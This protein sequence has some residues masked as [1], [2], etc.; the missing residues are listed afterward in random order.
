MLIPIFAVA[1]RTL[2]RSLTNDRPHF[3]LPATHY[4][5]QDFADEIIPT[6][7]PAP[8]ILFDSLSIPSAVDSS[9]S[10][11]ADPAHL[12]V[13]ALFA[14]QSTTLAEATARY[15]LRTNRAPPPH[16]DRWFRYAQE[17][18]CLIDEYDQ[19]HRD[20]KPFYQLAE[21]DPGFFQG[22]I[23][24]ARREV[25]IAPFFLSVVLKRALSSSKPSR[26]VSASSTYTTVSL[27]PPG[28]VLPPTS[29]H[30][31]SLS[32]RYLS[33]R[34]NHTHITHTRI[35]SSPRSSLT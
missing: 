26:L 12:A 27:P 35:T 30:G 25:A 1:P 31:P 7:I 18:R 5:S 13:D 20:F 11:P 34:L 10:A 19:I 29:T 24:R 15:E 4:S 9:T 2:L 28:T 14:R 22:M 3:K 21:R 8:A 33:P 6:P 16:Y 17:R 23:A 32:P